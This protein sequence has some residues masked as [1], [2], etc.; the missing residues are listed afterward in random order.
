MTRYRLYRRKLRMLTEEEKLL[1]ELMKVVQR[2]TFEKNHLSMEEYGQAMSQYETKLSGVIE[3]KIKTETNLAHFF[4]IKGKQKALK[5][6]KERLY[7]L[8][9]NLQNDYLNK[10]KIE[11]RVYENMIKA[12]STRIIEIEGK[13]T[14]I[15]AKEA[16]S[17]KLKLKN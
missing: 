14:F 5:Q 17:G 8:V 15:E 3:D 12:Y 10:G 1:L 11:T 9:K 16:L 2:E 4:K 7:D 13:L 6:E